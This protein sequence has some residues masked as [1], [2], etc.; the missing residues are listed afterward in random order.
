MLTPE[1]YRRQKQDLTDEL[2]DLNARVGR[3]E[4][5]YEDQKEIIRGLRLQLQRARGNTTTIEHAYESQISH[6]RSLHGELEDQITAFN[7]GVNMFSNNKNSNPS[8][9]QHKRYVTQDV[10]DEEDRARNRLLE[11]VEEL[12]R[13]RAVLVQA[14]LVHA[15][16]DERLRSLLEEH[17]PTVLSTSMF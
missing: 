9:D 10:F 1:E 11:E 13:D 17:E 4:R 7:D 15:P 5:H 2:Q 3:N 8:D 16:M 14:F 12:R 6:L